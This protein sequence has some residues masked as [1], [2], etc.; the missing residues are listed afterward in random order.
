[1]S[2]RGR[3]Y[4]HYAELAPGGSVSRRAAPVRPLISFVRTSSAGRS[5]PSRRLSAAPSCARSLLPTEGGRG[6]GICLPLRQGGNRDETRTLETL[7]QTFPI[8]ITDDFSPRDYGPPSSWMEGSNR[9]CDD[10]SESYRP[11]YSRLFDT[12]VDTNPDGTPVYHHA[13]DIAAAYGAPVV[14]TCPGVVIRSWVYPR[15]RNPETRR[16]PG[17][18]NGEFLREV[19]GYAR[20]FGPRTM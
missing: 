8:W 4:R 17:A 19:G 5:R 20:I 18:D 14:S 2:W 13:I 11:T 12:Q 1:M 10:E 6:L 7:I 15:D 9:E 16:R 3:P